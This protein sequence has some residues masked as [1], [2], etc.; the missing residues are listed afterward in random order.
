M[1]KNTV[2]RLA[3]FFLGVPLFILF[4][5]YASFGRNFLLVLVA[6]GIQFGS[7][8]EI[9]GLFEK[10]GIILN[11][12]YLAALSLLSSALV[13]LSPRYGPLLPSP[14][15]SLE[16]L[17]I[18]ALLGSLAAV[19]PFA[20]S[21]KEGLDDLL[22][23]IAAALFSYFYCG[24][25]GASLVYIGSCF[26]QHTT[27]LFIFLLM[28]S[29]NDSMAWLVGVTLGRRRGIV[30]VSPNKSLAGFAGGLLGSLLA[31][32]ISYY[33]FP[34][35]GIGSLAALLFTGLCVGVT[36]I[37]GDLVE[38]AL[39]RSAG[40]KDSSSFI[41]GRGGILDSFD[42]LLFSAPLFIALASLWGFFPPLG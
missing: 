22:P 15:S 26:S 8:Y 38:S 28:T 18:V 33:L 7:L 24:V 17:L 23:R 14:K 42:S 36:V 21:K 41:P 27:P 35:A 30:A 16:I 1:T 9:A 10:K 6:M 31:A 4:E 39:K 20:F 12:P 37:L 2:Q 5:L 34:R 3:V 19:A 29:G 11:R 40:V 13:Y 25:L 32:L